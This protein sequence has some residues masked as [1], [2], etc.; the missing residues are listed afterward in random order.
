M[1]RSISQPLGLFL[2]LIGVT[3][4]S[5]NA[6][7]AKTS[8]VIEATLNDSAQLL[9]GSVN[10]RYINPSADTL[11][12]IILHVWPNGYQSDNTSYALQQLELR[13]TSFHFASPDQYG[14]YE[15]LTFISNGTSLP[16]SAYNGH[17]DIVEV[18]LENPLKQGDTLQLTIPFK[19]KIPALFSQFGHSEDY[20]QMVYWYPFPA[21]RD[22]TGWL[23]SPALELGETP[24]NAA[25]FDVSIT[26]PSNYVVAATGQ[27]ES[28]EERAFIRQRILLT[29]QLLTDGFPTET[30]VIPS[31]DTVKTIRYTARQV[32]SFSWCASKGFYVLESYADAGPDSVRCQAFFS[33]KSVMYWRKAA[34]HLA[35]VASFLPQLLG[36]YPYPSIT[37]VESW[38][39]GSFGFEQPMMSFIGEV[40]SDKELDGL[41]AYEMARQWFFGVNSCHYQWI[42]E[43]LSACYEARYMNGRYVSAQDLDRGTNLSTWDQDMADEAAYLFLARRKVDVAPN[44][45]QSPASGISYYS[46]TQAKP[47]IGFHLLENY[48]TQP[49]IDSAVRQTIASPGGLCPDNLRYHLQQFDTSNID[50]FF[51]EFMAG[52]KRVDYRIAKIKRQEFGTEVTVRNRGSLA[53]PF[54]LAALKE[55][56]IV[57]SSW[58]D[59][60]ENSWTGN[61]PVSE[62]DQIVVDPEYLL[63]DLYRANNF[64]SGAGLTNR[65]QLP[66]VRFLSGFD[67]QSRPSLFWAPVVGWNNYEKSM[68]G[69][70]L[71]NRALVPRKVEW[72]VVPLLGGFFDRLDL[73]GVGEIHWHQY[74]PTPAIQR[75]TVGL[76]IRSFSYQYLPEQ[77]ST[78]RYIRLC[79]R[80][81]IEL[82]RPPVSE[83]RQ[84]IEFRLLSVTQ[85]I[86]Q[87]INGEVAGVNRVNQWIPQLEY[88]FEN[89]SVLTPLRLTIMAEQQDVT[90]ENRP[91][92]YI[93]LTAELEIRRLYRP[94][95]SWSVRVFSGIFV[96]NTFRNSPD[97]IPQ[98]FTLAY[99]GLNDYT[100]SHHFI[101]R[102][103]STGLWSRQVALAEG[104]F[105]TAPLTSVGRSNRG[106]VALNLSADLPLRLPAFF[107]LAAYLDAG[108]ADTPE[109]SFSDNFLWSG[110]LSLEFARNT[111]GI[112]LPLVHAAP[113]RTAL[114]NAGQGNVLSRI[115]VRL[116]LTRVHPWR[117]LDNLEL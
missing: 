17:P 99:Q 85:E 76:G 109:G 108:Y 100:M 34:S 66:A 78:L 26:L 48:L 104:G 2:Y 77:G 87:F 89:R 105:K 92:D 33:N 102:S 50:W 9:S 112:Y 24:M 80:L 10:L 19:L 20:Y 61:V 96:G 69:I 56:R 49:V 93:K 8:F 58:I 81:Q 83:N 22:S 63:P 55:G 70:A 74:K 35:Q 71:Y 91:G 37:A 79:P 41:L 95:K 53:L 106:I 113:I 1:L 25:D 36:A 86:P 115:T 38:K 32:P 42:A 52:T 29:E 60:T 43:G 12:T 47:A 46:A 23:A 7:N 28:E 88:R 15:A 75:L 44:S 57:Y 73:V 59:G 18:S 72:A 117:M 97:P 31:S 107:P 62:F 45:K 27:L 11:E 114:E 103:E 13:R 68:A 101:G 21:V 110:G 5:V 90:V 30:T 40:S 4:A 6:Q 54:Q 94:T 64:R 14:G 84:S 111:F 39:S 16:Y 65:I 116:D 67:Q 51:D 82:A 3:L 98:S